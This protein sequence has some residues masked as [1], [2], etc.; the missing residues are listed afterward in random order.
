MKTLDFNLEFDVADTCR[1]DFG[2][3][4]QNLEKEKCTHVY[5][6]H[7]EFHVEF[8]ALQELDAKSKAERNTEC[9]SIFN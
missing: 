3:R 5:N 6:R 9:L 4:E 7:G 2:C 1:N 8:A